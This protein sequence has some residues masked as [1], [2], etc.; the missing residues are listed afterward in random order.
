MPTAGK[1][2]TTT[3]TN[4]IWFVGYTPYY[5]LGVWQGYDENADLTTS[6]DVR[7]MWRKIM[8]RACEGLPIK[9]FPARPSNIEE[10]SICHKSGKLAVPGICD[11]D[12]AGNMTYT[13]YFSRGTA[14][15]EVCD[16][17][18]RVTVCRLSGALATE[19]CPE[20]LRENRIYRTLTDEPIGNTDDSAYLLPESLRNST[21]PIHTGYPFPFMTEEESQ[22]E[23]SSSPGNEQPTDQAP[24]T[25]APPGP[26]TPAPEQPPAEP[27][28]GE[29]A[30]PIG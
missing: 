9:E 17:H 19:F 8:S 23:E 5:T 24:P 14:P 27:T 22:A 30:P 13:E 16:H 21:C 1:S 10:V 7:S 20:Q 29:A 4:D 26:E 28:P 3:N 12:P 18:T 11:A 15:T 6:S 2:G 25:Q